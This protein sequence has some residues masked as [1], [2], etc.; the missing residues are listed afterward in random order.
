M[1]GQF[2]EASSSFEEESKTSDNKN[3]TTKEDFLKSEGFYYEK[4]FSVQDV[5]HWSAKQHDSLQ[6]QQFNPD[7]PD[8]TQIKPIPQPK[9]TYTELRNEIS[10]FT[11]SDYSWYDRWPSLNKWLKQEP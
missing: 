11:Y 7:A 2:V 5:E 8:G 10:T 4:Y 9:G 6:F 1:K 3:W